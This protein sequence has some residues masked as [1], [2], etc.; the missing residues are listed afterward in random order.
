MRVSPVSHASLRQVHPSSVGY[1]VV[2]HVDFAVVAPGQAGEGEIREQEMGV[3]AY[4]YPGLRKPGVE[5]G[6]QRLAVKKVVAIISEG[7][8]DIADGNPSFCLPVQGVT[9]PF[10]AGVVSENEHFQLY[11][12]G[13][14]I[15]ILEQQ[16][17]VARPGMYDLKCVAVRGH[18]GWIYGQLAR[19][20]P[21]VRLYRSSGVLGVRRC[22]AVRGCSQKNG[23]C[24]D[25]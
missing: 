16:L 19:K 11:G 7:I 25:G 6:K 8:V 4:V 1:P 24:G 10:S 12:A 2:Y 20:I 3:V 17:S 15:E 14:G 13:S 18:C 9:H 22:Q 5:A 23:S 21:V